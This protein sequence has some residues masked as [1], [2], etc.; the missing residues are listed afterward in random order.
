M[1]DKDF[2]MDILE[3]EKNMAVNMTYALNEASCE[4]L[5]KEFFKMFESISKTTKELFTYAFNENIYTLEEESKPK[6]TK[7][8]SSLK[9]ELNK[10]N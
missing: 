6:I 5:Y 10:E 8:I 9:G 1:A 2:V 4:N 3:M 7:A